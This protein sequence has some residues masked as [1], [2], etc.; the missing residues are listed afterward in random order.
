MFVNFYLF[1]T[2]ISLVKISATTKFW[3]KYKR[4]GVVFE[5]MTEFFSITVIC[6][7]LC[8]PTLFCEKNW[9]TWTPRYR[10]PLLLPDDNTRMIN[11]V[12]RLYQPVK[13]L[14]RRVITSCQSPSF[15][16]TAGNTRGFPQPDSRPILSS[17]RHPR[18]CHQLKI[19][20]FRFILS[21]SHSSVPMP[22]RPNF[23]YRK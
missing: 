16:P 11:T 22:S 10:I 5:Q 18:F 2:S 23:N 8:I 21:P 6:L 4:D 7:F 17:S 14:P 3:G 19:P 1:R 15:L 12:L 13:T 9:N 20:N